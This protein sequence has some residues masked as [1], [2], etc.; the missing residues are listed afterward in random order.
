MMVL[1]RLHVHWSPL[2]EASSL[3]VWQWHLFF[4]FLYIH[5][6][7]PISWFTFSRRL[8]SVTSIR[9]RGCWLMAVWSIWKTIF[10]NFPNLM[11]YWFVVKSFSLVHLAFWLGM[12]YLSCLGPLS[13]IAF[14]TLLLFSWYFVQAKMTT[15]FLT[16]SQFSSWN[17]ISSTI[18]SLPCP[19]IMNAFLTLYSEFHQFTHL[20]WS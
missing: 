16:R 20:T 1:K 5:E 17:F 9:S 18:L 11:R 19:F 12:L 10:Y 7:V 4:S 14:L 3:I 2:Q 13:G 15:S 8:L 6:H